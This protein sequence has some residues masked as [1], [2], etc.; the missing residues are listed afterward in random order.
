MVLLDNCEDLI[1]E[2]GA[3]TD[4]ALD[5]A[6]RALLTGPDHGVK[7]V[8]TTRV[9]PRELLLVEPARQ[10]RLN[11][12]EGLGTPFAENILRA[13]DPDA[14]LGLHD[15]PDELLA[16]ARERT[17]GFPRA[18]EALAAILSADRDTTL[19]ELLTEAARL[20][21]NVVEALV[22]EA[23][24]RLDP[25]AQQVMQALAVFP[26]PVPAVAVDYL[27]QPYRAAI[28]AAPVLGR[29]VNMAF[30]RRDAGRYYLHQVD[31][32]YSLA[33][34]PAGE[35][36]D[37][38]ADPPPFTQTALRHRGANYF[39][40]TRTPRETWKTLD[41]LAPQLA[42][43][44]LRWQGGDYDTA[45]TVLAG[46]DFGYLRVWGHYRTQLSL[47][48]RIHGKITDPTLN[49]NHLTNLGVCYSSLG[50]YRQAIDLH[51]QALDIDRD[52][53]DRQG[54]GNQLTGLG[55]CHY[56][57]GEYRRAIDLY[58]QSLAIAR[59]IG[60]RQGEGNQLG[61]LGNCHAS[62]GAY[63]RAIDLYTQAL[64]IARDIGDRQGEG[65]ALGGLGNCHASLSEYRRAIDLHTQALAIARDTGNRQDEGA[66]L[67]NL[68]LY[69]A[70]L[71]EYRRAI[72]LHTQALAIARD[73]GNRQDEGTELCNLGICHSD[74][75]DY[76]QA[77]DL[78]T[79]ALAIA[80]DTGNRYNEASTLNYLGQTWLAS[81]DPHQAA[82]VLKQAVSIADTTGDLEPGVEARSGLARAQLQLGDPAAALAAVTAVR[83][84]P[85]YLPEEPTVRLLEGVALLALDRADE[86]V[87]AFSQAFSAA[88]GLLALADTNVAALQVRALALSGLAAATGDPAQATEAAEALTRAQAD[89]GAAGVAADT[90]R[91]LEVMVSH[92][93][94]GVL[95]GARA[96]WDQ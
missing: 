84:L 85:P 38:D 89:T 9:A 64:A 58:T 2:A 46:I 72:D 96:G 52:I 16:L 43:F 61:G 67:A 90:G 15:A 47:H 78:H 55:N 74:S 8:L 40:I 54:E 56:S 22:G 53:G 21:G 24:S 48:E 73:T 50:D 19:P 42:E 32:D 83:E 71:G 18:L 45:A 93:R 95:A 41:D 59:E 23:F 68:G 17:R 87:W 27:L 10:R 14:S 49:A 12:D 34:I 25:L 26:A 79:Q 65:L 63:R 35:S 66:A 80:R 51:T 88:E 86:S 91:L 75:G 39:E 31:R 82:T 37:R 1:D 30:V 81:G 77:I 7:V 76:R 29:L 5:E 70:K 94:S 28:D 20:P 33:R 62:L 3:L 57:L 36:A 60:S 44:E 4:P 69:H 92:D 6:L 11:L 13:M